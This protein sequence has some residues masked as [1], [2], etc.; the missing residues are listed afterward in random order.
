MANNKTAPP[1]LEAPLVPLKGVRVDALVALKIIKHASG[2]FPSIV[3]GQLLGMEVEGVIEITHSFPFPAVEQTPTNDFGDNNASNTAILAPRSKSNAWYQSEMMKCLREINVD[4]NVMGWYQSTN[5]GNFVTKELVENQYYYQSSTQLNER[6]V[7][8]VYDAAR[9]TQGALSIRSFRLTPQLMN[10]MKDGKFT[11]ESLQKY[12]LTYKELFQELPVTIHNSH[13]VNSLLH[14]LSSSP[15]TLPSF[16]SSLR[17]STLPPPLF[18]N[19]DSL[20]LSIDPFLEKNCDLL[21]DSIETHY[22]ELNNAQYYQRQ[23]A[24]EHAKITAWQQKRKAENISRAALKQPPLPEDEWQKL[25]KLPQEPSRLE[26]LLNSRQIEQYAK[27][28]DGFTAAVTAKMFAV[29]GGLAKIDRKS[30]V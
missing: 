6:T 30:V 19:Y 20:D 12:S 25:F 4:S 10:A 13:L 1:A 23:L 11:T 29:N 26:A 18:P 3:T 17:Q 14:Q 16:T 2:A 8:L 27:Q 28:V 5:L 21:L 7:A 24:R 15:S 9:S 22:T